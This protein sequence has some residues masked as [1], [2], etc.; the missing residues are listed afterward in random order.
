MN[1]RCASVLIGLGVFLAACQ[2]AAV[3]PPPTQAPAAAPTTAPA[4]PTI[5]PAA[6]PTTAPAA[7]TIAP[8]AAPT[9]APAPAAKPTT[10]APPVALHV[11][12]SNLIADNLPEWLA[13]E[14]GIFKENGLDV[15]LDNIVSSTGIPAVLSGQVQIAHLGGSESLSAAAAGGD[16][17]IIA[18]TGP[19]YPFVFMAPAA[20]TSV[21]QIKGKKIGVSNV[22]SSSDIATRVMLKK[23]GLD[24]DKDVSVVAVGSLQNRMAALLNGAIEGGVAQP[25]D[26]LALEDAGFHVVYDL[27]AQKLP[28]VGDSIVVQRAWLNANHEVAQRYIDSIVQAIARSKQSKEQSLPVLQ[29][30][31]KNDDPRAL[32]VTYDFFVGT[33]TPNYPVVRADLFGDAIEQLSATNDKIKSFD[34]NKILDNQY[35]QSAMDRKVGGP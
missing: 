34:I 3:A 20:I 8:A 26:Q 15:T 6:A 11:S 29:K 10:A 12:Y 33:V 18:I 2:S 9:T 14:S 1:F 7:P 16:L 5:A 30:Y 35:V 23:V 22:G 21:D 31:L 28:S 27:A 25:P 24:P 32:G 19:V 17:V 13:L 4:A